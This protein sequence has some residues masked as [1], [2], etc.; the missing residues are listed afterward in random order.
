ME[1]KT[2]T[3][4]KSG[5]LILLMISIIGNISQNKTI[6]TYELEATND[7]S[8]CR[9]GWIYQDSGDFAGQYFCNTNSG[10]RYN[11]CEK[12]RNTS[13]GKIDYYCDIAKPIF[14]NNTVIVEKNN[15]VYVDV[16][17]IQPR[18]GKIERCAPSGC[19]RIQ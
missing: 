8:G 17:I 2:A 10:G 9:S 7:S 3:I 4:A 14:I 13:N 16:P 19:A 15:T 18:L 12:L 5:V 6:D 11:Y 1:N